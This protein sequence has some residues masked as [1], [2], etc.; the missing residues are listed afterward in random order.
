M[1]T[2]ILVICIVIGVLVL[3]GLLFLFQKF[4][5]S[6]RGFKKELNELER[7]YS[8]LDALLMGQDSQYIRRLEIISRS[9]LLYVDKHNSF[10]NRFKEIFEGDDKFAE[11]MIKQARALIN[12]KQYK[13]IKTVLS[14]TRKAINILEENVNALDQDLTNLIKPEE[15]ARQNILHLKE[16]Y[17][18][19]KQSFYSNSND[20]E[21]VATSF[22]KVFEKLD[23]YIRDYENHIE[24]GEYDE[25]EAMLPTMIKVVASLE[26]YLNV[27][28]NLCVACSKIVPS[29]IEAI[30][31][32]YDEVEKQDVPLFN[33][34]FKKRVI[35][36]NTRLENIKNQL[37]ALNLSTV[38]SDLSSIE[39]E[40]EESRSL[41]KKELTD[42][43]DF[44]KECDILYSDV[45]SLEKRFVKICSI[46]PELRKV[47]VV[48]DAKKEQIEQ[49]K[50][51]I[52]ELGNSKRELDNFVHSS[53]KQ[54]YSLLKVKLDTLKKDYEKASTDVSEFKAYLDSLK[55]SSEEAYTL[56]FAYY[57]H[58][59]EIEV[60]LRKVNVDEFS[61]ASFEKLN[62]IYSLLNE[63]DKTLK[64][65]PIDV[66]RINE[67]VEEL[68]GFANQFFE[69]VE[70]DID[71]SNMAEAALVFGNRDRNHQADI[72]QQ[73]LALEKSFFN[74]DFSTVYNEA[75]SIY[76]HYHVEESPN[77]SSR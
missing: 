18:R 16:R 44:I 49:L 75:N 6:K 59:R 51:S 20:L 55:S 60:A 65:Q 63:I 38:E 40:I 34:F 39:N 62:H 29:K 32:E 13:T 2:T 24:C 71:T 72:H 50:D 52:N 8:Y 7:K 25:A 56:V 11:S 3:I 43:E 57:Y 68:K 74:G 48:D 10:Q 42:K 47:Y 66:N 58:C 21:I 67:M 46:L 73:F 64:I 41:L 53:I 19:V 26:K 4:V 5:L 76:Q 77:E 31:K 1:N 36:W 22:G 17:R 54:P 12:N 33:L 30:V 37:I 15:E 35:K 45:I 70:K 9:N 27:L 61:N 69:D 28:P 23:I 14:D